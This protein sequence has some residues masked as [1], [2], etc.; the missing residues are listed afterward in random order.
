M[1]IKNTKGV[2]TLGISGMRPRGLEHLP[3]RK[4]PLTITNDFNNHL[5]YPRHI[6]E[7]QLKDRRLLVTH[8]NN[9]YKISQGTTSSPLATL[10]KGNLLPH[11]YVRT[12]TTLI[13]LCR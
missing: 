10:I 13:S 4:R 3:S 11:C 9:D 8:N 5:P 7:F 1:N 2:K 6:L 12:S